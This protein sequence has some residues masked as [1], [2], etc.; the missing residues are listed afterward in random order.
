VK[1]PNIICDCGKAF[2]S[3]DALRQHQTA[4]GHQNARQRKRAE[5]QRRRRRRQK[6][7]T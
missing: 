2:A 7:E 5:R 3:I 6:E 1:G 4:M